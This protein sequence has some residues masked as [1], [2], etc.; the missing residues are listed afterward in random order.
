MGLS[1]REEALKE[2][3]GDALSLPSFYIIGTL[4]GDQDSS[5]YHELCHAMYEVNAAYRADVDAELATIAQRTMCSMKAYLRSEGY[6]NVER[7]LEDEV[8]AYLSEGDELGCA[9]SEV[10]Q[11]TRSFQAVFSKHAGGLEYLLTDLLASRSDGSSSS[12]DD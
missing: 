5:L 10:F 9:S 4:T 6:A 3:L 2:I 8:H 7:I 12:G 11:H 1:P